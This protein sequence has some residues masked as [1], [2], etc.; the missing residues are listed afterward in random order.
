MV[1]K[2]VCVLGY[3][4]LRLILIPTNSIG[5]YFFLPTLDYD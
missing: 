3:E 5:P 1:P 4:V 2:Y